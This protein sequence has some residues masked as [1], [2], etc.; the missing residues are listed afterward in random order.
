MML[1]E[2]KT[3]TAD[4][5]GLTASLQD[6]DLLTRMKATDSYQRKKMHDFR[7]SLVH[8]DES[9]ITPSTSQVTNAAQPTSVTR[10]KGSSPGCPGP[11]F[12]HKE[13]YSAANR[14]GNRQNDCR[15]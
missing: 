10:V 2:V 15:G 9:I 6:Q 4:L 13:R 12:E 5:E 3:G 8:N 7:E 14:D 1:S 11:S